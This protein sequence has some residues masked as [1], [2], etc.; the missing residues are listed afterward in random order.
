MAG[1]TGLMDSGQFYGR[2]EPQEVLQMGYGVDPERGSGVGALSVTP[3]SKKRF[4][5]LIAHLLNM[6]II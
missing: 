6:Q 4:F 2:L 1:P 3:V 5:M